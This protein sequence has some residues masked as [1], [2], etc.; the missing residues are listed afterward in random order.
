MTLYIYIYE[1]I[2][3]CGSYMP[4][5]LCD[6]MFLCDAYVMDANMYIMKCNVYFFVLLC[7]ICVCMM[8]M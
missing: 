5:Y 1:M 7:F 8:Q 3:L 6:E 2:H 4:V